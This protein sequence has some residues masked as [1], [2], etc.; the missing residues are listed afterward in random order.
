MGPMPSDIE[1]DQVKQVMKWA[2]IGECRKI[3]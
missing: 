3:V 2:N 1:R